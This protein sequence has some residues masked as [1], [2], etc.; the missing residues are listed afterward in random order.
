MSEIPLHVPDPSNAFLGALQKHSS[1]ND[2]E[3]H[4]ENLW[5]TAVDYFRAGFNFLAC[6]CS[7][8]NLRAY[9]RI[10]NMASQRGITNFMYTD[11]IGAAARYNNIT[12][13]SGKPRIL[14]VGFPGDV[15]NGLEANIYLTKEFITLARTN[16][17]DALAHVAFATSCVRDFASHRRWIDWPNFL[18]RAQAAAAEIIIDY[19]PG[20]EYWRLSPDILDMV[21]AFPRG[22]NS[23]DRS[24][25]YTKSSDLPMLNGF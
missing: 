6:S 19:V 16:P 10:V 17:L 2:F 13:V 25:L 14:N 22:I 11:A 3:Q 5:V 4:S 18:P 20:N 24:M 7:N 23:L 9:A 21:A 8:N 1:V 15:R 12:L